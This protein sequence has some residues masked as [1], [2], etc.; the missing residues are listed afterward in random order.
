MKICKICVKND[1]LCNACNRKV[2]SG[3]IS[4]ESVKISRAL[5]KIDEGMDF[6]HS[7]E[8]SGKI[9]IIVDGNDMAKIIGKSGKNAKSLESTLGRKIK[10][11]AKE[12]E[13]E[14][15]EKALSISVAGVNKVYGAEEFYRVRI[16]RKEK[17]KLK[18]GFEKAIRSIVGSKTEIVFE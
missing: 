3:E 7:F 13:K 5:G 15:L 17:A 1:I 10:I 14:M 6:I 16:S 18:P 8:A 4:Q 9:F 12:G 11:I 2:E